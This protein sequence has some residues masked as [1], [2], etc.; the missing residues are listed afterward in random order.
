VWLELAFH[1]IGVSRHTASVRVRELLVLTPDEVAAWLEWRGATGGCTAILS[2]CNRFEIYWSGGDDLEPWFRK[3]AHNRGVGLDTVL[4]RLDRRA[5]ILHLYS[6]AAGLD[7]QVLGETEIL[8]QV[9]SAHQA[10]RA[11]GSHAR[12]CDAI[13]RGAIVAGRRV[14]RRPPSGDILLQ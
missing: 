12:E 11:V 5:A 8:G 6:V 9:R 14:R 2:T 4:T 1:V 10:A 13:F 3:F 7:S